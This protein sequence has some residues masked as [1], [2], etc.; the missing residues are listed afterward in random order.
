LHKKEISYALIAFSLLYTYQ[1]AVGS[2]DNGSITVSG[3]KNNTNVIVKSSDSGDIWPVIIGAV[4]AIGGLVIGLITYR[5]QSKESRFLR[6]KDTQ[7]DIIFPI[8]KEFD[9][10]KGMKYAKDILDGKNIVPRQGW[11]V[12]YGY[13]KMANLAIILRD[14]KKNDI[15]DPG[16][17]AIRHSFD[18]LLDFFCKLEYLLDIKLIDEREIEYFRYY[19]ETASEKKPIMDYINTYKFPLHIDRL[20]KK[21]DSNQKS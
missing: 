5:T 20:L 2:F 17:M 18:V 12:N 10:S 11:E 4:T 1:P 7:K 14:H 19:I 13:Y 21:P 16:E 6:A 3:L 8:I 15:N 9:E